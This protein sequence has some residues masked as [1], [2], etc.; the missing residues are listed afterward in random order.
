[1][2]H[3]L[4][5]HAL[6]LPIPFALDHVNA[7]AIGIPG[8]WYLV[9]TGLNTAQGRSAWQHYLQEHRIHPR[10]VKGIFVTHHHSDHY[11]AAGWLQDICQAPVYMTAEDIRGADLAWKNWPQNIKKMKENFIKHGAPE[12]MF[13][14]V[15]RNFSTLIPLLQPFPE[16]EAVKDNILLS[17]GTFSLQIIQTAGHS[18]GHFSLLEPK[19]RSFFSGD[20]L[21]PNITTNVGLWAETAS[22]DPLGDYLFSLD[23]I[24]ELDIERV[25]PAH[26]N[27]FNQPNYRIV[28]MVKHHRQRL[29]ET[30][31][32]SNGGV[33]AFRIS[34]NMFGEGLSPFESRLALA[35][36]LAHL[37]YLEYRGEVQSYDMGNMIIYDCD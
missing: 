1:M 36:T 23:K 15:E 31:N 22:V 2:D 37:N 26:G 24:S 32:Y 18:D 20:H 34:G 14:D 4:H 25:Y 27:V 16:V 11:G 30:R 10:H 6:R 8:E 28:E 33:T 12:D 17:A 13:E 19:T 3:A 35:E 7:Y 29:Q 5:V 21:L 9:D